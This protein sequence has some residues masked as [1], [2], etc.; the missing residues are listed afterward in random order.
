MDL[1]NKL[2]DDPLFFK[3]IFH[4]TAEVV[5]Y[6]K[7]YLEFHKEDANVILEFKEQ[8]IKYF[9]YEEKALTNFEKKAL[10]KRIIL[11]I[12]KTGRKKAKIHFIRTM[13][14]FTLQKTADRLF[15][16]KS[17]KKPRR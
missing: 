7:Y 4:S 8:I 3:W 9:K 16:I 6:W 14:S 11:D 13:K 15:L 2:I 10:A 17:V 5:D 12:E 1:Y